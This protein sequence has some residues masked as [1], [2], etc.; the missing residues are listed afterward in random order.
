M[1]T[2]EH[3]EGIQLALATSTD[4]LTDDEKTYLTMIQQRCGYQPLF[5]ELG[6]DIHR[7]EFARWLVQRGIL[8]EGLE[9]ECTDA[10]TG[11]IYGLLALS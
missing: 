1:N 5:L 4:T 6:L 9:A 3:T 8:N 7:L 10:T 11:E 2:G